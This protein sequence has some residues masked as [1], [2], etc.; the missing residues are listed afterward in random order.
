MAIVLPVHVDLE[1]LLRAKPGDPC[2]AGD[3]DGHFTTISASWTA[4]SFLVDAKCSKCGDDW[5]LIEEHEPASLAKHAGRD[6]SCRW[7]DHG[8][9][10]PPAYFD[11]M[12]CGALTCECFDSPDDPAKECTDCWDKRENPEEH[13]E[14][15]ERQTNG[16]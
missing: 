11:C 5:T 13:A 2:P 4:E 12:S 7:V 9:N 6:G 14:M 1:S 15:L 10:R 3:C 8:L 16:L